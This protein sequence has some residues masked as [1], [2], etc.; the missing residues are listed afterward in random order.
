MSNRKGERK[1][2]RMEGR[3]D[4][5]TDLGDRKERVKTEIREVRDSTKERQAYTTEH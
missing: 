2:Q 5:M 1:G 3:K 4:G